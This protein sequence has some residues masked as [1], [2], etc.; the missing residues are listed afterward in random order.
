LGF[1]AYKVMTML[2]VGVSP[3]ES[4]GVAATQRK[5][6]EASLAGADGVVP[7]ALTFQKWIRKG[8]GFG[9]TPSVASPQPP[10]LTQERTPRSETFL[11]AVTLVSFH[12]SGVIQ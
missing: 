2:A 10:L 7:L 1:S 9:T 8:N 11:R 3:P 12:P 4:G 6:R 5:F